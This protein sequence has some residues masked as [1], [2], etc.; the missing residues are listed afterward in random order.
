M[1]LQLRPYAGL[2]DLQKMKEL[3]VRGRKISPHSIF[4][5]IGDLDWWLFYGAAVKNEPFE[6]TV[7]L[8]EDGNRLMAWARLELKDAYDLIIDPSLRGTPEEAHIHAWAEAKITAHLK[9]ADQRFGYIVWADETERRKLLEAQGY[10]SEDF[11]VYF[12]PSLDKPLPTPVLPDGF[13]F[14]EAMRPEWAD[15]RAEVH[16]NAF[17]PSRM[18]AAAY[19]HFMTA[20][21]Y[22]PSLDVVVAAPDGTFASFA[23]CWLDAETGIGSFEPVGTRDSMQRKGLGRAALYEGLRR[24]KARGMSVV[25]VL[26]NADDPG[27]IAFYKSAS[28]KPTNM[29]MKYLKQT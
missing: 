18:T 7:T 27:N 11:M 2:D 8:W 17:S 29:I 14:I 13:H 9:Q 21:E 26:T 6:E 4:P 23:M 1:T 12:T 20:P 24:M 5:H 15:R 10:V 16:F 25:T 22:D 3:I 28:F 19:T